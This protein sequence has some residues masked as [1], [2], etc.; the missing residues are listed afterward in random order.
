MEYVVKCI[1]HQFHSL[2]KLCPQVFDKVVLR[3]K[4]LSH[5]L[6][7]SCCTELLLQFLTAVDKAVVLDYVCG[8]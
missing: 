6:I 2:F 5:V 8:A 1:I 3:R 7:L 4:H